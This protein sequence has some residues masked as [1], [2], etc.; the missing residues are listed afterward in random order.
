MSISPAQCRAGRLGGRV[1]SAGKQSFSSDREVDFTGGLVS[2]FAMKYCAETEFR[3][4]DQIDAFTLEGED[5]RSHVVA[6]KLPE[7][8]TKDLSSL[9]APFATVIP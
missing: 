1:T 3:D 5:R 2:S 8:H 9:Q 6:A 4:E 7:L